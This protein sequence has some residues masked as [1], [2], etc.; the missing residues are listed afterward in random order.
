[1]LHES[2]NAFKVLVIKSINGCIEYGGKVLFEI[3]NLLIFLAKQCLL[4]GIALACFAVIIQNW[5]QYQSC[6]T[7]SDNVGSI[8]CM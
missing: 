7:I 5:K 4:M 1:M 2:I 6:S 8:H 3:M